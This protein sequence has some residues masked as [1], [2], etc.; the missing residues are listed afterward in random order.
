[1]YPCGTGE[2]VCTK[3]ERWREIVG[4][5]YASSFD[6]GEEQIEYLE[7]NVSATSAGR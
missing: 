4:I 5:S 3:I 2:G 7:E 1:L 6:P